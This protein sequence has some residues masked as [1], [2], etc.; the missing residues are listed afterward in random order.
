[1]GHSR[2]Y[3]Q[4]MAS[5]RWRIVRG[6]AAWRSGYRCQACGSGGY[7]E[8]HHWRGYRMLGRESPEDVQMLCLA[9]HR[10][11]HQRGFLP[12]SVVF[13]AI[14]ISGGL[15]IVRWIVEMLV[16]SIFGFQ[17]LWVGG[18]CSPPPPVA[19]APSRGDPPRYGATQP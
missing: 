7:L 15:L 18:A 17:V 2:L 14:A 13:G 16:R 3:R 5:E 11:A 19:S 4:T 9:C 12:L 6:E 10:R 1:M 8:G